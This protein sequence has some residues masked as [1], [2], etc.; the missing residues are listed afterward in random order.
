MMDRNQLLTELKTY[1]GYDQAEQQFVDRF[2]QLLKHPDA[3]QRT[4]LPGHITGSA[5]I[6][7]E[8]GTEV[9]L[10]HH[11]KLDKWLQPGGHADG[12]E[13]VIRVASREAEEETGVTELVL[14]SDHIFDL[15][16]HVIPSRGN[17]PE[18]F[19]YD[20]RYLFRASRNLPLIVTAESHALSWVKLEDIDRMSNGNASMMRMAQKMARLL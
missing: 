12:D 11:A 17:M 7:N 3:F 15:D 18:H 16:I 4:H 13:N 20:L 6:S 1:S 10:T 5:W 14:A 19:H 9:L 2:I 8:T